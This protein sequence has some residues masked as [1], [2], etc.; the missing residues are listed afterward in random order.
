VCSSD[1]LRQSWQPEPPEALRER[2]IRAGRTQLLLE[3]NRDRRPWFTWRLA[4]AGLGIAVVF[5]TNI[6]D[7]VTQ[8]RVAQI[9]RSSQAPASAMLAQRPVTLGQW[10]RSMDEFLSSNGSLEFDGN[11]MKGVDTP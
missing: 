9:V 6:S 2:V 5:A 7:Q 8:S 11:G 1:L 10:R 3:Q 4:L